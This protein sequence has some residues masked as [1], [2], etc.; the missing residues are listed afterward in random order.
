[1]R[2]LRGVT[3]AADEARQEL[4]DA[5][6]GATNRLAVGLA[7][8]GDA[9]EQL[10]ETS[11]DKLEE[12][13]F[14]PVQ[15]AYGRLRKTHS[16]FADRHRMPRRSF[17]PAG[18][19]AASHGVKGFLESAVEAVTEADEEIA[20]LQDSLK[21]VEVGDPDLRA[22]LAE[23]RRLLADVERASRRFVSGYGR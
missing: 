15:V 7:A 13:L 2:T 19:R 16:D 12:D 10:D 9:Y 18:S 6:A 4:L 23:V 8:L 17:L 22:G 20:A 3:Y 5:V 11:A 21:P 1:V 14:R